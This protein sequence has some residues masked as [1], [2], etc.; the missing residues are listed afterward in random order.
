L[1]YADRLAANSTASWR[2]ILD[3]FSSSRTPRSVPRRTL[4][5]ILEED[6]PGILGTSVSGETVSVGGIL[7]PDNAVLPAA[8][9]LKANA[10]THLDAIRVAD[11]LDSALLVDL[12]LDSPVCGCTTG[13]GQ[14]ETVRIRRAIGIIPT[15]FSGD[16]LR[17]PAAGALAASAL[18]P[19]QPQRGRQAVERTGILEV[20]VRSG[21]GDFVWIDLASSDLQYRALF[22]Y[23]HALL[24]V[25]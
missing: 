19:L 2:D 24:L 5:F 13:C 3:D 11:V 8:R 16:E 9:V 23:C 17:G 25:A 20:D 14:I 12:V 15:R 21:D 10:P 1:P 7:V 22:V 4:E 18:A 6:A